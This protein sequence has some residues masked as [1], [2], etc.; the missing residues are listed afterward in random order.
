MGFL[1]G[2]FG[3]FSP[4][5]Q[6]NETWKNLPMRSRKMSRMLQKIFQFSDLSSF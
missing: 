3:I 1:N 2:F 5:V 6:L 4:K